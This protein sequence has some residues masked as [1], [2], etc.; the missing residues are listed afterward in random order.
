MTKLHGYAS[1]SPKVFNISQEC[2]KKVSRRKVQYTPKECKK[3]YWQYA[4]ENARMQETRRAR[5]KRTRR[6]KSAQDI[7]MPINPSSHSI[8]QT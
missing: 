1:P 6:R 8:H 2:T 5:K 7:R 3:K 4:S